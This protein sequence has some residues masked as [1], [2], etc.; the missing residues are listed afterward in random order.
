VAI[1]RPMPLVDPV[2]TIVLAMV[3]SVLMCR[4]AIGRA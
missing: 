2:T 4:D 3:H 1:A